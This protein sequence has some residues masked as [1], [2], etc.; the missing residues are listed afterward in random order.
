VLEAVSGPAALELWRQHGGTIDLMM[1]DMMMPGGITGL[2]L[3]ERL[4][5]EK[6]SLKIVYSSGYSEEALG[7]DFL[8]RGDIWL[9]QKPYS[10]DELDRA[11]RNALDAGRS[12][13]GHGL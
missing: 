6:P 9:L 12:P 3:A 13:K 11:V 2:D 10:P 1:T 8:S 7:R 5:Q 4:Q